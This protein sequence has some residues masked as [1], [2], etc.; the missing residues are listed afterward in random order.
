LWRLPSPDASL[1][2]VAKFV[3]S[4]NTAATIPPYSK[5]YVF[6]QIPLNISDAELIPDSVMLNAEE[7]CYVVSRYNSED[8]TAGDD[9]LVCPVMRLGASTF[10]D[11]NGAIANF[12]YAPGISF[13]G[14]AA[15]AQ[16]W[17]VQQTVPSA[18]V[19]IFDISGAMFTGLNLSDSL[20]IRVR[21]IIE[22]FPTMDE[23]V[24]LT[25]ATPS[26]KRDDVAVEAYSEITQVLPVGVPVRANSLGDWFREAAGALTKFATPILK[27]IPHPAAQNLALISGGASKLLNSNQNQ[28]KTLK[29]MSSGANPD[30]KTQV[31]KK[32]SIPNNNRLVKKK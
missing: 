29:K 30:K 8:T 26:P 24:I 3:S 9:P 11:N 25:L 23:K 6:D 17:L 27:S 19:A 18:Q 2:P 12:A 16:T 15:G 20:E 7:G 10:A 4:A 21:W 14:L 5:A 32:A 22:K 1:S 31:Q 13:N 28:D